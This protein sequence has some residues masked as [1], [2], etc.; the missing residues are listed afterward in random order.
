[1]RKILSIVSLKGKR[2]HIFVYN[3]NKNTAAIVFLYHLSI[4]SLVIALVQQWGL[5]QFLNIYDCLKTL[6]ELIKSHRIYENNQHFP[7]PLPFCWT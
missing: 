1:M 5:F 4:Q 6:P 7:L 3:S 2:K